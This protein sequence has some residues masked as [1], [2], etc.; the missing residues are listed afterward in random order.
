MHPKTEI[1]HCV[2]IRAHLAGADRVMVG[3]GIGAAV[4]EQLV[5][6]HDV[7]SGQTLG[8]HIGLERCL[9]HDLAGDLQPFQ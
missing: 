2:G 7:R 5:V 8:L 4:V 1:D 3:L 6:A 9:L